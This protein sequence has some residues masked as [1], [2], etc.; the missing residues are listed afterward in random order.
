MLIAKI[1]PIE[2]CITT[3]F[4]SASYKKLKSE[5]QSPIT[6]TKRLQF[7]AIFSNFLIQKAPFLYPLTFFSTKANTLCTPTFIR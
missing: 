3:V 7:N 5:A 6:N 4:T 1:V 2:A